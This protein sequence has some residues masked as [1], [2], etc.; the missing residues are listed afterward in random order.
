MEFPLEGTRARRALLLGSIAIAALLAVQAAQIELADHRVQSQDANAIERGAQAMTGDADAWDR[1]GRFRQW[2]LNNPD[3]S[4]AIL[5]YRKAVYY[6]PSSPYYWMDLASAYEETGDASG[7]GAAYQQAEA[8]Y[9]ISAEVAW[10]YG[11]FLLREQE[12]AAGMKEIERAVRTDGSLL[13]LA[14]SRVW[15]S[16]HDVNALLDQM[17]PANMDSYFGAL[18]FFESIHEAEPALVIWQRLLA[19]GKPF[20]LARSFPFIEELIREDRSDDARQVWLQALGAA[21][22]PHEASPDRSAIWDGGFTQ[23]FPNGGLGWRWE[24]P[25]GVAID[26]DSPRQSNGTRSVRLDFGG[27]TNLELDQP[28]QYVPV[29]PNRTYKFRGYLRTEGIT[30]ESGLRFSIFDPHHPAD[31]NIV[32]DNLTGSNPWTTVDAQIS[33]RPETHFLV[34]RLFRYPSRLFENR[35]SGT[36]WIADLSLVPSD[37]RAEEPKQ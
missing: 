5:D 6:E 35:L 1:L 8:V 18:D 20:P 29:E 7:A 22:L 28:L 23:P 11:N 31:L 12:D 15:H 37:G 4:A 16:S 30:T 10:H 13:P 32:T 26:F 3:P 14:L 33:T 2:D 17:L 9:P 19:L 21:A 36:A 27:G 24:S 25:L 34:V